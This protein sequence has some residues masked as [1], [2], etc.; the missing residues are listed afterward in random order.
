MSRSTTI[1]SA[2]TQ[3]NHRRGR[4]SARPDGFTLIELLVV[5]GIISVVMGLLL[6]A[7][8]SAREAAR[9]MQCQNHLRQMG[10]AFHSYHDLMGQLPAGIAEKRVLQTNQIRGGM[11]WSGALL[12]FIERTAMY[13]NMSSIGD[14]DIPNTGNYEAQ[15]TVVSLY[16]CPSSVETDKF[17]H[18]VPGRVPGCYLGCASGLIV[19]ESDPAGNLRTLPPDGVLGLSTHYNFKEVLDGMSSTILVGESLFVLDVTGP[20]FTGTNQI[21]DHWSIGSSTIGANELSEG[22]ASTAIPI[23]TSLDKNP[24]VQV[25][26]REL[27]YSSHHQGGGALILYCDGHVSFKSANIDANIFSAM[28]TRHNSEVISD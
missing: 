2:C 11:F 6:P 9:R 16:V 24:N 14:W 15:R 18:G 17:D 19:S 8:Q 7:V 5:I 1:S 12:P 3:C 23:N 22:L 4:S 26:R 27:C 25:E 21:V 13:E 10:I 20:D 28:G